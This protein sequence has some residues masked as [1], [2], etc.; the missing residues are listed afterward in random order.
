MV[1]AAARTRHT[2]SEKANEQLAEVLVCL[3]R[4]RLRRHGRGAVEGQGGGRG[5]VAK[6]RH[7]GCRG[8]VLLLVGLA[9]LLVVCWL[10][11]LAWSDRAASG[12]GNSRSFGSRRVTSRAASGRLRASQAPKKGPT[13]RKNAVEFFGHSSV[14][15]GE[16]NYY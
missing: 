3:G 9:R 5:N 11:V 8:L 13:S 4:L 14:V 2:H 10:L 1:I 12:T 15:G 16:K 7:S 6:A